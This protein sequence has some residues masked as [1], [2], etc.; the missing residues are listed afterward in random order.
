MT[1]EGAL[2]MVWPEKM[3]VL[4]GANVEP[5]SRMFPEVSLVIGWLLTE[6]MGAGLV[7]PSPFGLP[8]VP[9]FMPPFDPLSVPPLVSSL[10]PVVPPLLPPLVPP[11]V[12]PLLPPFE[13]PLAPPLVPLLAPPTVIPGFPLI[14]L[15]SPFSFAVST[16]S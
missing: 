14:A 9:S 10:V 13:P 12:T 5:E 1:A 4:P 15:V 8:L 16:G 3:A 11:F 7:L 6:A 2:A